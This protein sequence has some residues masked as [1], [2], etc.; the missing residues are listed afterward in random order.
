MHVPTTVI[1]FISTSHYRRRGVFASRPLT[2]GL[3]GL[4]GLE[5]LVFHLHRL[6]QLH[7]LPRLEF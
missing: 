5:G 6:I 7:P 3:E 4:E 1:G 2:P